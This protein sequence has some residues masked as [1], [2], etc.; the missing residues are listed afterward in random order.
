MSP[1]GVFSEAKMT[2]KVKAGWLRFMLS[3]YLCLQI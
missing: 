2:E 1:V 3:L